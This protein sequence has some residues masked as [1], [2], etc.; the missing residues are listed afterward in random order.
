MRNENK[1]KLYIWKDRK[2]F[3]YSETLAKNQDVINLLSAVPYIKSNNIFDT[4]KIII[5]KDH[6]NKNNKEDLTNYILEC[7]YD[8]DVQKWFP[9]KHRKDKKQPNDYKTLQKT[10]F[11]IEENILIGDFNV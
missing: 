11:N 9:L 5:E 7:Y 4:L 6:E 1:F 8:I 2:K 10:L 3:Y